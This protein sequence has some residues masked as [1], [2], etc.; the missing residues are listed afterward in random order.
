MQE[1]LLHIHSGVWGIMI[2]LFILSFAFN[3]Q[4]GWSMALRLTYLIMLVTGVWMLVLIHF[5]ILFV[6][7]G[8]LALILIGLMEMALAKR[9]RHQSAVWLMILFVIDLIFILLIGYEII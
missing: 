4:K 3:R 8:V 9:N 7:K 2:L 1:I 5:P 6:I